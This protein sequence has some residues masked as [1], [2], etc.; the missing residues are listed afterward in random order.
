M[1]SLATYYLTT[2]CILCYSTILQAQNLKFEHISVEQGLS[3]AI[4]NCILQDHQGFIWFATDDGLN[5]YDGYKIMTYRHDPNDSTSLGSQSMS[6]GNS[7]K[8][9]Y[10]DPFGELWVC[11]E[12]IYKFNRDKEAFIKYSNIKGTNIVGYQYQ[13]K[14]VI[15][16]GGSDGLYKLDLEKQ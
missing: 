15:W 7:G 14:T 5:K 3:N 9:L 12:G 10:E 8:L 11:I 16:I 4:V 1:K 2:V 13:G 6:R